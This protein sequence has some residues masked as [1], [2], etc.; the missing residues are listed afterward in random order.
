MRKVTLN[1]GMEM[2]AWFDVKTMNDFTKKSVLNYNQI[3][4]SY[5]LI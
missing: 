1:M 5:R 2:R 4:E 3:D